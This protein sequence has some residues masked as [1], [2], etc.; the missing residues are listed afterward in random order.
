[1]RA[2][3][4]LVSW[5]VRFHFLFFLNSICL[6]SVLIR[7]V[8]SLCF[9]FNLVAYISL[10]HSFSLSLLSLPAQALPFDLIYDFINRPI[11][12]SATEYS[13]KNNEIGQRAAKL[14]EIGGEMLANHECVVVVVFGIVSRCFL[15]FSDYVRL[16]FC[17]FLASSHVFT[18]HA[19][20]MPSLSVRIIYPLLFYSHLSRS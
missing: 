9:L 13:K 2:L 6:S 15:S 10:S 1:M 19:A 18:N 7:A 4:A 12:M 11:P 20:K 8:F 14:L 5:Y 17:L 3:P 16:S